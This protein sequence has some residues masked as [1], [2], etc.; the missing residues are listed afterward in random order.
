M[1]CHVIQINFSFDVPMLPNSDS[2]Y[3]YEDSAEDFI[4]S[5]IKNGTLIGNGTSFWHKPN[6][7]SWIGNS[8]LLD[9][10]APDSL[11]EWSKKS[12]S[13]LNELGCKLSDLKLDIT[14]TNDNK[15]VTRP[16]YLVLFARTSDSP[17]SD[18]EG[19]PYNHLAIPLSDSQREEI[20]SW[21]GYYNAIDTIWLGFPELELQAYKQLAEVNS[22]LSH[23]GTAICKAIELASGIPTYYYLLRHSGC[24]QTESERKCPQCGE[25]WCLSD[26]DLPGFWNFEFRCDSCRLVSS[27]AVHF[28]ND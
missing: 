19:F 25:K 10:L 18:Q 7:Y 4:S 13:K 14:S 16:E 3:D 11:S 28:D 1:A 6:V 27:W 20:T 24:L 26:K 12:L 9:I 21:T 8:L 17:I 23:A 15:P 22:E 2:A 5:L